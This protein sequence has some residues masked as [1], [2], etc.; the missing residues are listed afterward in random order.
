MAASSNQLIH[1][2]VESQQHLESEKKV[3]MVDVT[4]VDL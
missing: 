3:F 1:H 4:V 2:F